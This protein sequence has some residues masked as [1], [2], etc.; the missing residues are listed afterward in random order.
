MEEEKQLIAKLQQLKQIKPRE[1]WV[2][3]S[4]AKIFTVDQ[5][6]GSLYN[7]IISIF[8]NSVLQRKVSYAFAAF[9]FVI[10]GVV[11]V[12]SF[13]VK[14]SNISD[15][16]TA[17]IFKPDVSYEIIKAKSEDLAKAIEK[18]KLENTDAKGIKIAVK[19]LTDQIDKNPEIAR[20]VA[21]ELK[22]SGTLASLDEGAE[23]KEASGD[24][25]KTLVSQMI[26]DLEKTSLTD[27]QLKILNKAKELY[28]NSKYY[29][30]LEKI[31]LIK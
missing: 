20:K 22:N 7:K 14:K 29:E 23:L 16:S 1:S 17:A 26:E 2:V 5:S 21:V 27:N 13:L 30:A 11:G 19:N 24:L 28:S 9:I 25:Y 8:S 18:Y 15:K 4:K 31:L 3:F 10:I 12:N 6:G